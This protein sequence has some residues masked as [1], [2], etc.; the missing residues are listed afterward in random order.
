MAAGSC[1]TADCSGAP[2]RELHINTRGTTGIVFETLAFPHTVMMRRCAKFGE[3]E[4]D[5][6]YVTLL[7]G[8]SAVPFRYT[9]LTESEWHVEIGDEGSQRLTVD[10]RLFVTAA[11]GVPRLPIGWW[12]RAA[13]W[14]EETSDELLGS[15][16]S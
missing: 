11:E 15:I 8:S 9:R 10:D 12:E 6:L 14:S 2:D 16:G 5:G 4:G 1:S 7:R 3:L 13:H